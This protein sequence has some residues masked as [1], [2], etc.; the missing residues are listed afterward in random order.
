MS[1]ITMTGFTVA[2]LM[3][4]TAVGAAEVTVLSN[5]HGPVGPLFIDGTPC[6]VGWVS[7]TLSK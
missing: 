7:D 2:A 3:A 5:V 4:I 1:S 6:S